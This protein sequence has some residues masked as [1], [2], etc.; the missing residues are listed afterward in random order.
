MTRLILSCI[1]ILGLASNPAHAALVTVTGGDYSMVAQ[2]SA[3]TVADERSESGTVLGPSF[4]KRLESRSTFV[5]PE[6]GE[7]YGWATTS[8]RWNTSTFGVVTSLSGAAG[9]VAEAFA[10]GLDTY[11]LGASTIHVYFDLAFRS[12]A[13]VV[14]GGTYD[15]QLFKKEGGAWVQILSILGNDNLTLDAG[16]YRWDAAAGSTAAG[17]DF[18]SASAEFQ[19]DVRPIPISPSIFSLSVALAACVP[20]FRRLDK[21]GGGRKKS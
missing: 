2:T 6:L 4:S 19:M 20:M 16:S 17:T 7:H 21:C 8:F 15:T 1:A 9:G 14:S 3:V 18:Y 13:Y 10:N 5:D 12:Y 11:A